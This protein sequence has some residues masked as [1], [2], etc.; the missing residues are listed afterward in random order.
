MANSKIIQ[1]KSLDRL[2]WNE[3]ITNKNEM[4]DAFEKIKVQ[5][6]NRPIQTDKGRIAEAEIRKWLTQFLPKKF[7][8]GIIFF[9]ILEKEKENIRAL[10]ELIPQK[11]TEDL[12]GY[13]G[14]LILQA[15]G[16]DR[17]LTGKTSII[18]S[19]NPIEN[20]GDDLT[21]VAIVGN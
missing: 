19:D 15:E 18:D 8:M 1:E 14:G 2:G 7:C 17:N 6:K 13:F 11:F 9:E 21:K 10:E 4:L 3:F 16:Q 12:R 20:F 5:T